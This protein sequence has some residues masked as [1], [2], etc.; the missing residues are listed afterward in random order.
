MSAAP[1]TQEKTFSS[2]NQEQGNHYA[3]IRPDYHPKVYQAV[4]D[5]HTST[6]GLFDVL[7]DVG[8]GP[9]LAARAL[10][11]KFVHVIGIDPS[12]GM[13]A[14]AHS[15]GGVTATSEPI[16]FEISTAEELGRGL[17]P[18]IQDESVDLITASN[19]AHWFDMPR[20]WQRAARVLKPGGTV[21]LWTS[22]DVRI[23]PS[24]PAAAG[25]QAA[26]D[27]HDERDLVPFYE[28]GNLLTRNRYVGL[29]LPWTLPTPIPEFDRESF[30]RK[31]WEAG[32]DFF[33]GDTEVG[34]EMFEKM[35]TTI[36]AETRWRQA[37]PDLVGTERDPLK[38]L[39][40][41]IRKLLREAGV[42]PGK[43]TVKGTA[44]GVLLIVKKK[45]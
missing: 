18:P 1:E 12:D 25:I 35:M 6:G 3:K 28:P 11:P 43:E 16:R 41:E 38:M 9:G 34:L 36:S 45:V 37:N 15:L 10:G 26:I 33:L 32:E 5:L 8:C 27:L 17:T 44:A 39:C 31:E 19:A 2:Y 30:V 22:G 14:T 29:P 20:F 42:E 13:I 4:L 23:H 24:M 40:T 7:L 21:A